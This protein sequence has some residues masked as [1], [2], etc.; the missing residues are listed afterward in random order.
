MKWLARSRPTT[1][2]QGWGSDPLELGRGAGAPGASQRPLQPPSKKAG[3]AC[4][5]SAGP[6]LRR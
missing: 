2:G 4:S 6:E 1:R 3:Q 5:A